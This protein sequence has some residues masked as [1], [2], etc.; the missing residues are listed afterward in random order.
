ML[1]WAALPRV[2][3]AGKPLIMA[4]L[5]AVCERL[6]MA[7]VSTILASGNVTFTCDADAQTIEARLEHAA[8]VDL[9]LDTTWFVRSHA[10][11]AQI[12]AAAPFPD[13]IAVRPNHV[14]VLFHRQALD[15]DRLRELA[16]RHDGPN[17]CTRSAVSC[18]SIIL[19]GLVDP[20]SRSCL[21]RQRCRLLPRETGIRF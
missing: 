7:D 17:R 18:T 10:E 8:K 19:R 21:T 4:D 12:V 3:N 14:Q 9:E 13:A 16:E 1:R 5:R 2:I 15:L 20:S 11:L 6:G